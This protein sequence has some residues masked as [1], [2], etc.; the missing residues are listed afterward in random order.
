MIRYFCLE[1]YVGHVV[2]AQGD[3]IRTYKQFI[4]PVE[5]E[6]FLRLKG[7]VDKNYTTRQLLGCELVKK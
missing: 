3:V 1:T 2:H 4:D 6:D 7:V 5:L